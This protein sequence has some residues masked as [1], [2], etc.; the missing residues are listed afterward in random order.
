MFCSA[1][2]LSVNYEK[3]LRNTDCQKIWTRCKSVCKFLAKRFIKFYANYWPIFVVFVSLGVFVFGRT[4]NDAYGEAVNIPKRLLY[5]FI[6]IQ[7]FNSYNITW[8]FN[9]LIIILYLIF[10]LVHWLCNRKSWILMLL[11]SFG[12][13]FYTDE[14]NYGFI[15]N[16]CMYLFPF[17]LGIVC[18]IKGNAISNMISTKGH[19]RWLIF[20]GVIL[21]V[22]L[23]TVIRVKEI[24]PHFDGIRVD[25]LLTLSLVSLIV[26]VRKILNYQFRILP[27]IGKYSATMYLTHTFFMLYWFP[28]FFLS[29]NHP[30]CS[31]LGLFVVSLVT[32]ML[33]EYMKHKTLYNKLTYILVEEIEKL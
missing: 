30:V 24:I 3:V 6:G 23:C 21:C 11:L 18:A 8:W 7:G 28:S 19:N 27:F 20:I 12:L 15:P 13:L 1:Y 4:L 16:I 10:P 25:G 32:A 26:I 22:I 2:G 14:L 5:D 33:L 29:A 9:K 17:V 31:V